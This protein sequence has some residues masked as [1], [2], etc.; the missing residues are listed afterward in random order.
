MSSKCK[1]PKM[2]HIV[3]QN[4]DHD[5][6]RIRN[7]LQTL[8]REPNKYTALLLQDCPK[9][10]SAETDR[11]LNSASNL[12]VFSSILT[13]PQDNSSSMRLIG[14]CSESTHL[15]LGRGIHI[16]TCQTELDNI[17]W[18]RKCRNAPF[19][20]YQETQF[21]ASNQPNQT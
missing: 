5:E 6:G 10:L 2:N 18:V 11:M 14:C 20:F 3:F 1:H 12:A 17:Q 21:L 4:I 16:R 15:F 9:R 7:T 19:R 13:D 8:L